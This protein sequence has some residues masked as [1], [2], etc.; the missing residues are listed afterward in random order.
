MFRTYLQVRKMS[1]ISENLRDILQKVSV[2]H[3]AAPKDR[4]AKSFPR[5]VAVSK[6]KPVE[7]IIEAYEEGHRHFGENYIQ[8]IKE[9]SVHPDILS[10][11]PEIQWHF[12]G[13]C[14]S[15]KANALMK[16]PNLS[17][18]ETVTSK[19][20]AGLLNKQA[21]GRP[22]SVMVQINTSGE[23]NKNGLDPVEGVDCA[24]YIKEECTNLNLMGLMTIGNL[25]NSMKANTEGDNPDFVALRKVRG[26]V[27]KALNVEEESLELS[28]GMSNDFEEA[29][30]MGSTNVRVGSSIFGAR[31]YAKPAAPAAPAAEQN[32]AENLEKVNISS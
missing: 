26:E 31:N 25:G 16:C 23:E 15:N 30:R 9:K 7:M 20:L 11:C 8:E 27:A 6:T 19:K 29:I 22:V 12:I 2:S 32:L 28:M 1:S 4:R 10:K 17:V 5:L 18:V 21:A 3:D 14:Q 13:N 24:K